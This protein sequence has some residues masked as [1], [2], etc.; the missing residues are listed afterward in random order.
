MKKLEKKEETIK[1]QKQ[2]KSILTEHKLSIKSFATYYFDEYEGKKEGFIKENED[3]NTF[4]ERFKKHLSRSTTRPELLNKYVDFLHTHDDV[5]IRA[6][7]IKPV[8]YM[9]F[10]DDFKNKDMKDISERLQK[11]LEKEFDEK[12]KKKIMDNY[13]E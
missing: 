7:H 6:E 13:E 3:E 11:K 12:R 4:Y 1:L 8:S 5:V 10:D 9:S 2:I